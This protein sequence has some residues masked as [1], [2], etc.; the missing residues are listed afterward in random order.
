MS[1]C[2]SNYYKLF[3]SLYNYY[4]NYSKTL[5][6]N[7]EII[8]VRFR[9]KDYFEL[10]LYK[11]VFLTSRIKLLKFLDLNLKSCIHKIRYDS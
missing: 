4:R 8:I 5:S 2:L 1:Y 10:K 3:N 9:L 11:I 6:I 7:K